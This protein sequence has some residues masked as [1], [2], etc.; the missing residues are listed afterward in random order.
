MTRVFPAV[1]SGI[2]IVAGTR[3]ELIKIA[4]VVRELAVQQG[5]RVTLVS[6]GQQVDLLPSFLGLLGTKVDYHLAVMSAGQPLNTL[7]ARTVTA[8]DPVIEAVGP[9]LVV[10]QGDTT[11][12]LAGALAAQMRA[13]PVAHIEAGLR[14]GDPANPFPEETNR[15]LISHLA[16]LHCAPTARNR[17][18][19]LG[20]GIAPGDIVVTG[21]PVVASLQYAL[22]QPCASRRVDEVL[23]RRHGLKPIVLT[24]H[25][26]ESF[27][28]PLER[29]LHSLK[30][31]VAAEPDTAL[32]VP[33][34]LNPHVK[35]SVKRILSD[36]DRVALI[37]PL[38][39]PCF[40]RLLKAAWLIVSDSGG[41]Q[42][43]VASLG[44]PLLVLRSVT[45][46]PEAIE[47]GVAK[48][49]GEWPGQLAEMLGDRTALG[50]W[51]DSVKPI[52][53]PFGDADSPARI[54]TAMLDFLSAG[55]PR[56]SVAL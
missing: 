4:P 41:V 27:G 2:M 56:K 24:T 21:N 26:R 30:A 54:A 10:V 52:A 43:E 7:L 49:T 13:V 48:L 35:Q 23:A 28:A 15:R 25:R 44:K 32:V 22:Q 1:G 51:I 17:D 5:H 37:E 45:E 39:Y 14:T 29:N 36:T 3:P 18:T 11:S 19:L 31:F 40:L 55:A 16:A 47:A 53:N 9:A 38:D 6:T 8:L 50:R 42:E 12:A 20:E 34:H 33:V 46:R